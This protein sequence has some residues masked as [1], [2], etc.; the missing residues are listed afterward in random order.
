MTYASR[1][2]IY[3]KVGVDSSVISTDIMDR[4]LVDADAETDR[5]IQTTCVPKKKIEIFEGDNKNIHFVKKIPLLSVSKMEINS[6][7]ISIS[8]IFYEQTGRIRILQGAEQL[9]FYTNATGPDCFLEYYYG[10]LQ[11]TTTQTEVKTTAIAGT[12]VVIEVDSADDFTALDW[13]R[14]EGFDGFRETTQVIAK[15]DTADTITCTILYNHEVDSLVTQLEVPPIVNQ[16]ASVIGAIMA[17]LYMVGST[18]TFATSYAVP[19]HQVTKGVPYPHFN[20]NME[21]W[22]KER[23]FIMDQVPPWAI[24]S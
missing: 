16:L 14:I 6:T 9:Y 24:F 13:V 5:I 18:Y 17:A 8:K 22:V 4:I 12:S 15:D 1:D 11:D 7:A 21:A 23:K 10:W 20:R 2:E 19:D 3:D